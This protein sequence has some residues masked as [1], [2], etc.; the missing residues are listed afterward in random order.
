LSLIS[1]F[2]KIKV[3]F[4]NLI[5]KDYISYDQAPF[6]C[7]VNPSPI[8]PSPNQPS[9]SLSE[10]DEVIIKYERFVKPSGEKCVRQY[11]QGKS[12]GRGGFAKVYH[13]SSLESHEVYA[14]KIIS[15]STLKEEKYLQKV[16][17][18]NNSSLYQFL[19]VVQ[20]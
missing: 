18:F 19:L 4:C 8:L 17:S 15:K 16:H 7:H 2:K 3:Y 10:Y 1:F 11:L 13:F 20:N 6:Y 12:L 9:H 14:A 5:S